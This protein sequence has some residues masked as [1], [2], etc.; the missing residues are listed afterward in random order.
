MIFFR[1]LNQGLL[2]SLNCLFIF[3][4]VNGPAQSQD[5]VLDCK[6]LEKLIY[7]EPD[8]FGENESVWFEKYDGVDTWEKMAVIFGYADDMKACEDIA[9][10]MKEKYPYASYRCNTVD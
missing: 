10:L 6:K 7:K 1:K 5:R 3:L 9:S 2:V 4:V 8:V